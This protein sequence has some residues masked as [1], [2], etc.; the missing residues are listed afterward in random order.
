MTLRT[1]IITMHSS[2]RAAFYDALHQSHITH[3]AQSLH[4]HSLGPSPMPIGLHYHRSCPV[5]RHSPSIS[6]IGSITTLCVHRSA[7]CLCQRSASIAALE[8]QPTFSPHYLS[9]HT[10]YIHRVY[11][12]TRLSFG[13]MVLHPCHDIQKKV[14]RTPCPLSRT[15]TQRQITPKDGVRAVPK[16]LSQ[17]T[18]YTGTNGGLPVPKSLRG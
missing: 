9:G 4:V 2:Q 17:Y 10:Q 11:L 6:M 12:G 13:I 18:I 7:S 15:L 5:S 3:S 16:S 8:I 14:L 1:H